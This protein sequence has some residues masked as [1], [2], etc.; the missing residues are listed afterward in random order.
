MKVFRY[1]ALARTVTLAVALFLVGQSPVSA[2]LPHW[3]TAGSLPAEAYVSQSVL[4]A[5]GQVLASGSAQGYLYHPR[6]GKWSATRPYRVSHG[7]SWLAP[8]SNRKVLLV[9]DDRRKTEV[10]D[11][12]TN[13][14]ALTGRLPSLNRVDLFSPTT[15][16]AIAV[17]DELTDDSQATLR[18]DES[19]GT[20]TPTATANLHSI[21]AVTE[22]ATG[23]V[24][25]IAADECVSTPCSATPEG[26]IYHAASGTWRP[27]KPL[28]YPVVDPSATRLKDGSVLVAGGD[29]PVGRQGGVERVGPLRK[30]EIYHPATDTWTP[31]GRM[32]KARGPGFWFEGAGRPGQSSTLLNNGE[33][34]V[35]GGT[36]ETSMLKSSEL[37]HPV[38]GKWSPAGKMTRA[39]S[40]QAA[41]LL[42]NGDVLLSGGHNQYNLVR[43]SNV[44]RP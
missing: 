34:L 28:P 17:I 43:Q 24:L 6:T 36:G 21:V 12:H 44:Y 40:D 15:N 9:S 4:L 41:T 32:L 18:Y 14:W 10:Y 19:S 11:P 39:R 16:G 27:A 7:N 23:D 2:S 13:R 30:A 8:L 1:G 37:Y 42:R 22:L 35:A 31:T 3:I 38:S 33:V 20:W 26:A 5:N 25:F 29:G